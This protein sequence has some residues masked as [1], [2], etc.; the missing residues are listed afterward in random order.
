[1]L[2]TGLSN[3]NL[4]YTHY[5]RS[6]EYSIQFYILFIYFEISSRNIFFSSFIFL[7]EQ[8]QL[9]FILD[10]ISECLIMNETV[11]CFVF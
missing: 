4:L 9:S 3:A 1:M 7:F 6:W 8:E 2:G 5:R 10:D 11:F